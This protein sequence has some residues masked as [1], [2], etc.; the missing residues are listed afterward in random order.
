MGQVPL[1][2]VA[3]GH[4]LLGHR[5]GYVRESEKEPETSARVLLGFASAITQREV[6]LC[7]QT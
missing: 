7:L 4:G 6:E 3:S 2:A 5:G 1:T